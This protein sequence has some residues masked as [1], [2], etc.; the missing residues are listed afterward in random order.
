K[1]TLIIMTSNLGADAL[2]NDDS[3]DEISDG[4]R[5]SVSAAIRSHFRPEFLNRIDET[6]FF[7]RLGRN[8]IDRIVD[9][10][11]D[12]LARLLAD[13]QITID[14]DQ[15]AKTWLANR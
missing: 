4:A 12:R 14:L 11:V 7:K 8:E 13:R 5:E 1:N 15:A 2:A 9:I 10:Q 3:D 6:V